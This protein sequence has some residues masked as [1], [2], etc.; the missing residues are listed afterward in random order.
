MTKRMR[1]QKSM[2]KKSKNGIKS[3]CDRDLQRMF[4]INVIILGIVN[5]CD[6]I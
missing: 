1:S 6:R 5:Y 4:I 3:Q 2:G